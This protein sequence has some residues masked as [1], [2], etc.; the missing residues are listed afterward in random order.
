LELLWKTI[1]FSNLIFHPFFGFQNIQTIAKKQDLHIPEIRRIP[2]YFRHQFKARALNGP[3]LAM[4]KK[5]S[6][7]QGWFSKYTNDSGQPRLLKKKKKRKRKNDC[8]SRAIRCPSP[9]QP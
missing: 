8:F 9:N 3:F 7:R 5:W 1:S 4:A 6:L 2:H